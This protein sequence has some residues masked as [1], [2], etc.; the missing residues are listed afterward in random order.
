MAYVYYNSP[1]RY[2]RVHCADCPE[3]QDRPESSSGGWQECKTV[4]F[5]FKLAEAFAHET[6]YAVR[7]C[8]K[9]APV[10]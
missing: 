4:E 9:C 8:E 6:G 2:V 10:R 5:A 7:T 3:A 1:N